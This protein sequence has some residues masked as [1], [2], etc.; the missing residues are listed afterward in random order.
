MNSKPQVETQEIADGELDSVAGG[1]AGI[2][3]LN[4]VVHSTLGG[5]LNGVVPSTLGPLH[6]ATGGV[7]ASTGIVEGLSNPAL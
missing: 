4:G 2:G 6:G 5:G 1:I 3:G 7:G